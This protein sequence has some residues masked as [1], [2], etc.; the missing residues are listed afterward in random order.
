LSEDTK[1]LTGT[2]NKIVNQGAYDKYVKLRDN[3]IFDKEGRFIATSNQNI[4]IDPLSNLEYISSQLEA[5]PSKVEH[6]KILSKVN[7]AK[8]AIRK[9]ENL[10]SSA[11]GL[12]VAVMDESLSKMVAVKV[13]DERSAEL[14][15]LF[16]KLHTVN[17]I[18][19]KINSEWG[20]PVLKETLR[21]FRDRHVNKIEEEKTL[22][23]N[24]ISHLRLAHKSSRIEEYMQLY[25]Y[26]KGQWEA[27]NSAK[28]YDKLMQI[29][30]QLYTETGKT[31]IDINASIIHSFERTIQPHIASEI[32]GRRSLND[33]IITRVAEQL[34]VSGLYLMKVLGDSYY[35]KF[36]GFG[37]SSVTVDEL[38]LMRPDS[39][40]STIYNWNELDR[41][42]ASGEMAKINFTDFKDAEIIEEEE[43]KTDL[44]ALMRKNIADRIKSNKENLD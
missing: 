11:F 1:A 36:T 34:K 24:D 2:E 32:L 39:P 7:G 37:D 28:D 4:K 31:E 16:G 20:Y 41:I 21:K 44:K 14:I 9:L 30:K 8:A 23:R 22:W 10:K 12:P 6:G 17:E 13:L 43:P 35:K 33:I 27:S 25:A 5:I 29:L 3:P 40:H 26:Y 38:N 19:E 15:T 18:Y 42:N